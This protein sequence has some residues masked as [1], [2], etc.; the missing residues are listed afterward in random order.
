MQRTAQ[1]LV[2]VLLVLLVLV[3]TAQGP[4]G[5]GKPSGGATRLAVRQPAWWWVRHR[6]VTRPSSRHHT[7]FCLRQRQR[8]SPRPRTCP[9]GEW[10]HP[11]CGARSAP[12]IWW[13][14]GRCPT[15]RCRFSSSPLWTAFWAGCAPPECPCSPST[16]T[17]G[18]RTTDPPAR[19]SGRAALLAWA[20]ARLACAHASGTPA[21]SRHRRRRAD[22]SRACSTRTAGTSFRSTTR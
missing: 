8:D 1:P 6:R 9:S 19:R 15:R 20:P 21:G 7:R 16:R 18:A 3:P 13:R 2:L 10:P 5:C 14:R 4:P 12:R 22:G 17:R 11:G